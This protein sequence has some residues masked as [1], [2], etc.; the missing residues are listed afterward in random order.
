M[1]IFNL[2][3]LSWNIYML[4]IVQR[5]M[6]DP[7]S[8]LNR[9]VVQKATKINQILEINSNK[10]WNR[11][12]KWSPRAWINNRAHCIIFANTVWL[13][14]AIFPAIVVF[15]LSIVWG[16]PFFKHPL[17]KKKS[18]GVRSGDR[19]GHWSVKIILSTKNICKNF[20]VS[21]LVC[22]LAPS[23]WNFYL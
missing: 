19:G 6:G 10:V 22:A 17:A 13:I 9:E 2:P 1:I 21:L 23:C 5:R 15:S 16:L 12:W 4:L 18:V 3:N 8:D 7:V 20:I 11:C 14:I